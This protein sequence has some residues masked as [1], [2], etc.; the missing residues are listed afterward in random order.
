VSNPW[1]NRKFSSKLLGFINGKSNGWGSH[2]VGNLQINGVDKM[3]DKH[4][5]TQKNTVKQKNRKM[6]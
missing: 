1:G 3:K 5:H 6:V 4:T 2:V